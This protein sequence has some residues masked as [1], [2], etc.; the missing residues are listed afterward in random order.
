[1][2]KN[3]DQ[4]SAVECTAAHPRLTKSPKEEEKSMYFFLSSV[5][6]L[7]LA[8][9]ERFGVSRIRDFFND[10]TSL[11]LFRLG[12]N[13]LH[14]LRRVRLFFPRQIGPFFR[15]FWILERANNKWLQKFHLHSPQPF[16][17]FSLAR[18]TV[19]IWPIQLK[20]P[21]KHFLG[22]LLKRAQKWLVPAVTRCHSDW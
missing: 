20:K 11:G 13:K 15:K 6:V 8:S 7:L 1:M 18:W 14:E 21:I 22:N 19:S 12:K 3:V 2:D 4:C 10:K 17:Y 5:S 9:V 16:G